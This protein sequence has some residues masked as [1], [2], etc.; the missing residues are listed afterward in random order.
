MLK[1]RGH[2]LDLGAVPS[3]STISTFHEC[4]YDGAEIGSTGVKV[5]WSQPGDRV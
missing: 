3:S 1:Q 2:I 4:V 5:K